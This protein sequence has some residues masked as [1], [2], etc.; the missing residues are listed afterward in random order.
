MHRHAQDVAALT[1]EQP[2]LSIFTD[3]NAD[4]ITDDRAAYKKLLERFRDSSKGVLD[5]RRHELLQG[6]REELQLSLEF[7]RQAHCEVFGVFV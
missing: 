3:L 4:R 7:C 6:I 5:K 2:E 1:K